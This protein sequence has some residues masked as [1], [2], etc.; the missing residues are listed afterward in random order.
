MMIMNIK[1]AV[2]KRFNIDGAELCNLY[3]CMCFITLSKIS[4]FHLSSMIIKVFEIYELTRTYK[5]RLGCDADISA[6]NTRSE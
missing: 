1:W 6:F 2:N 3:T 5:I 4:K